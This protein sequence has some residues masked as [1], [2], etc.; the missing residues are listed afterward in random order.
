MRA[1]GTPDQWLVIGYGRVGRALVQL[2]RSSGRRV[3]VWTRSPESAARAR[4]ARLT[5]EHGGVAVVDDR[6]DIVVFCVPDDVLTRLAAVTMAAATPN[7]GR[8]WLHTSGVAGA[9]ALGARSDVGEVG[10]WHPLMAFAGDSGDVAGMTGSYFAIDGTP[11]AQARAR[12]LANLAGG[13]AGVVPPEARAAYHAAAVLAS[14][15]IYGLLVAAG[16]LAAAAKIEDPALLAGL[17]R[18]AAQSAANSARVGHIAAATGP[19]VRGD[20][21]TVQLHRQTLHAVD[22]DLGVLYDALARELMH[23]AE[24][25][26]LPPR[27]LSA[28]RAALEADVDGPRSSPKDE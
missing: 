4:D 21:G 18:L 19:V 10:A 8:V 15:G 6:F 13:R 9:D 23:V 27:S 28:L 2:L 14:N 22:H 7:T 16:R 24:A 25:R 12:E 17:A 11:A 1:D 26:N 5:A 3:S 20:V